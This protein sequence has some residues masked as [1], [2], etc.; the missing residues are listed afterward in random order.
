MQL[1]RD[2]VIEERDEIMDNDIRL[3]AIGDVERLPG[4]VKEPLDALMRDSAGNRSMTLCLALSYGGR[5]S[6]VAAARALG[7]A[8]ARGALKPEEITEERLTAALQT[9]GLPQLDLLV[10]TSGEERLSNFLLWEA[11]YA[12]LYF[13]DTF[14]PDVRQGG[15]LPGAG[16]VPAAASAASAGRAS[17]SAAPAEAAGAH[18][19]SQPGAAGPDRRSSRCRWSAA[20]ILWREPLGLRRAGAAGRAAWRCTS[21]RPSR[22]AARRARLRVGVIALGVGLTAA[23]YLRA[24]PGAGLGAGGARRGRRRWC[25][26]TRA[27]SRPRARG[28]A[29][30]AFGV[31]YLGVLCGAAGAPAARR[32]ARA[33]LGAAGDRA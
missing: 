5:E 11:A 1:L 22:C 24:R 7:E 19:A 12:E 18:G 30:A 4:F 9:G 3:I 31:F 2:Y 17:R 23:L 32:A 29:L 27:R 8:A 15:A 6:I 21:T 26:S 14:W 20:L 33:R 10:R 16:V 28:W 25:C 13:T